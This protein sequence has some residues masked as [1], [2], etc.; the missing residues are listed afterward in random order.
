MEIDGQHHNVF[1]LKRP[2]VD[3]FMKHMSELYEI[4][5]FTASLSKYA[6]PVLDKFDLHHVINHRLFREACHHFKGTYIKVI[7]EGDI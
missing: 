6:N 7:R 3:D 2:G 4:V 5:I 1:V